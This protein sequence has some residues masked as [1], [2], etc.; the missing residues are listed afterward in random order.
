[1]KNVYFNFSLNA[2]GKAD[3]RDTQE[4]INLYEKRYEIFLIFLYLVTLQ[5]WKPITTDEK[6]SD[7]HIE[8][9]VATF[10]TRILHGRNQI[11]PVHFEQIC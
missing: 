8:I 6:L 2:L 10:I 9:Q 1:M 3:H 7:L 5:N 11:W 4:F